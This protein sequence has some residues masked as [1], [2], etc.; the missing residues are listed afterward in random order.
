ME[1]LEDE[2]QKKI[3]QLNKFDK[4]YIKI[5]SNNDV[6]KSLSNESRENFKNK[7]YTVIETDKKYENLISMS[8]CF[9]IGLG[10]D[11]SSIL[12]GSWELYW[13]SNLRK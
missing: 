5:V 12:D 4:D 10:F 2:L 1:V 13:M 6:T 7:N 8:S 9:W 11:F 3:S